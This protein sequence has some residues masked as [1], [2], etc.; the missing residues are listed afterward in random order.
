MMSHLRVLLLKAL[1]LL[2]A[3]TANTLRLEVRENGSQLN[4]KP[5]EF[6]PP[7]SPLSASDFGK[8]LQEGTTV[9]AL[10]AHP[11]AANANIVAHNT[12]GK[13]VTSAD[14]SEVVGKPHASLL[15]SA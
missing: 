7:T 12:F 14:V 3:V 9:L 10:M 13:T 11:H 6:E 4:G 5:F 8:L 15:L 1:L 2:L